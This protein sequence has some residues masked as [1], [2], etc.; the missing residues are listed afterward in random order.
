MELGHRAFSCF[1]GAKNACII[2]TE[3]IAVRHKQIIEIEGGD[4]RL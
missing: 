4:S 2:Y 3:Y 1:D